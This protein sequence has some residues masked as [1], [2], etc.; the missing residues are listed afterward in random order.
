MRLCY[1]INKLCCTKVNAVITIVNYRKITRTV[2]LLVYNK[3]NAILSCKST[4]DN[5]AINI[6]LIN[7]INNIVNI[8]NLISYL[9]SFRAENQ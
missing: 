6:R 8:I 1:K 9:G 2:Q 4:K 7:F 3:S 5:S